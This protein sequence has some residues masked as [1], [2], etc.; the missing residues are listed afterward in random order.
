MDAKWIDQFIDFGMDPLLSHPSLR[1]VQPTLQRVDAIS[2][3]PALAKRELREFVVSHAP[4]HP[5]VYGMI[6]A[7]GRLVYV[8]KSKLLRSRLLSYFLPGNSDE[9]AGRILENAKAIVWERQPSEFASL[10]REQS[11]I[12]RW[13]P[14]FNVVG[15]P[16]RQQSAFLCFGRGPAEQ[17]YVTRQWD[18]EATLCNG[19]FFGAGNL[20]RAVEVL[21]RLFL[22]RDCSPKTPMHLTDQLSL[23]EI[24]SRAGCL[25]A[26]LGTCL[27]P[28]RIGISKAAY[29]QQES[30]AK[31]FLQGDPLD[32][33]SRLEDEMKRASSGMHF[34]RAARLQADLKIIKWLSSRLHLLN[35]ARKSPPAVHFEPTFESVGRTSPESL[36]N[37][38]TTDHLHGLLYLIRNGGI[39]YAIST[40]K[41]D[42]EWKS[43]RSEI[44]AWLQSDIKLETKFCRSEDSLGLVT[45][46][47][48]KNPKIRKRLISLESI[49]Q[50][51]QSWDEWHSHWLLPVAA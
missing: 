9:K 35:T 28:C 37:S 46:W 7:L 8:G 13:Q 6:D 20:H 21:N 25:R 16:Q 14:R 5:G 1:S 32:S 47:F 3:S 10:L 30:L 4:K 17:L 11:L 42:K 33:I 23:F 26:E 40:P 34:E 38:P 51:P 45:A 24:E 44:I 41:S 2:E 22:L 39:E 27:A 36:A 48:Q 15:M 50:I 19:P 43:L 29:I 49:D 12:R 18:P 31:R